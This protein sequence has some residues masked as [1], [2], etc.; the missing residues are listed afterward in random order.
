MKTLKDISGN[1]Q[2]GYPRMWAKRDELREEAIKWI[3]IME[4]EIKKPNIYPLES[5]KEK[6]TGVCAT[7]EWITMFFNITD[8]ELNTSNTEKE[9][10]I[11]FIKNDIFSLIKLAK[12]QKKE[13][14]KYLNTNNTET[15]DK[16]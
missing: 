11:V 14:E 5:K 13:E 4:E 12:E 7:I 3:K 8:E 6:I 10:K 2:S 16:K 9:G 15:E 1:A